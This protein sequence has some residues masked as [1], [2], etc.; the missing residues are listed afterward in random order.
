MAAMME[1]MITPPHCKTVPVVGELP[2]VAWK[3]LDH[4]LDLRA[5]HGDVFTLDVG[6]SQIICFCHPTYAQHILRDEA[7]KYGKGNALW[8]AIRTLLGNGLPVSEGGFWMRQRRMMQPHFHR[9]SLTSM[10]D[11]MVDA[12]DEELDSWDAYARSGQPFD[13]FSEMTHIT[14]RVIVKTIFGSELDRKQVDYVAEE[15]R[16]ALDYVLVNMM[17]M[18]VPRWIP[19]PGR[20]RYAETIANLD[21]VI[22]EIIDKRAQST[23]RR[24]GALLDML[25]SAVDTDTNERMTHQELRD[26]AMSLFLAGYETTAGALGF[27]FRELN[28]N[29]RQMQTAVDEID[30]VLGSRRPVFADARKLP[31]CLWIVQE[32]LRLNS[33]A[34]WIPRTALEDDVIGSYEIKKGQEVAVIMHAIHRNPEI[35]PDPNRFDPNRFRP[36]A[37][38]GRHPLAWMPFG[39]G[40]R[41][42]IGKEFA[43]MEG[44]F[45]LARILAKYDIRPAYQAKVGAAL[46]ATWRP[47]GGVMA[48][49]FKRRLRPSSVE[50]AVHLT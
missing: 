42:C 20:K 34:Y 16:Y 4:F 25:M 38:Q 21:R 14:M 9:E 13:L 39:A 31:Q 28:G 29:P 24:G 43:L 37:V 45:I 33:P 26:E 48:R 5:R 40:Q 35:W 17:S 41:L 47:D 30:S 27:A 44:Q 32:A 7:K 6:L 22:F 19:F 18:K 46:G 1:T 11:L 49:I 8:D 2:L 3:K 12:I 10:A 36:E 15:M 23:D 50:G